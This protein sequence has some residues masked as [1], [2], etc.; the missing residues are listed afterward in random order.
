[1]QKKV[2]I[3]DVAKLAGVTKGTVSRVLSGKYYAS[4]QTI[5]AV[6]QAV[7]QLGYTPNRRATALATGRTNTV[8]VVM[9]EPLDNFFHD[10]TFALILKG[11]YQG[12]EGTDYLPMLCY[13]SKPSEEE[14]ILN[15]VN[16]GSVDALIHLSP[17]E[18]SR[19]LAGLRKT[20][21]PVVL[22]GFPKQ[23]NDY[24]E[25]SI[26]FADDELG[27]Q[28]AASYCQKQG[29]KKPIVIT[30]EKD[31]PAAE[32]RVIGYRKVFPLA[33]ERIYYGGWAETD[34]AAA[35]AKIRETGTAFD[36]L[37]CGSDRIARGA[38]T[39]LTAAGIRVPQ[40]VKVMGFDDNEVATFLKPTISTVA[41][42]ME[43][44][45]EIAFRTVLEMLVGQAAK[46]QVLD[47]ELRK[48]ESA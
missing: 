21:I 10:P 37:L 5:V 47:T 1:M 48:R 16:T 30:G 3:A 39:A 20:S 11:I 45:G 2:T 44:Q 23:R 28:M 46:W 40:D 13:S 7:T 18:D 34:G 36:C 26:V 42:P 6:Q 17:W 31:N 15:L 38:I 14:K 19:L 35:V 33:A 27:A 12:M 32:D 8:A 24:P 43:I 9:S 29:A 4:A 22:C 41:Q 25:F